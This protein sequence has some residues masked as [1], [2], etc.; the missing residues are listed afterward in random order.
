MGNKNSNFAGRNAGASD[1]VYTP[2]SMTQQLLDL[3][4]L[5][6][7][8]SSKI[9]EPACGNG[10]VTKVLRNNG[11]MVDEFDKEIDEN[12][13]FLKF[14]I[15]YDYII[16]NP[17]FTLWDKFIEKSKK[18]AKKR[19]YL[20]GRIEFLTGIDRFNKS[21]YKWKSGVNNYICTRIFLFIR[22]G[23]L[24]FNT[25]NAPLYTGLREDGCYPA[26]MLHYCWFEFM[27]F[28]E[29]YISFENSINFLNFPIIKFINNQQYILS[30]KEAG[31]PIRIKGE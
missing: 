29:A 12:Y 5:E 31:K 16:T 20:L 22:K 28:N 30:S 4:S 7:D 17:P 21:I 15:K 14:D 26:G 3:I 27:D 23:F 25:K 19:F 24:Q 9:L 6:I 11:Y 13:D 2:Y 8:K 10:A 1:N 18:I